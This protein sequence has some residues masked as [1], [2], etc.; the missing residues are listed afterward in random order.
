MAPSYREDGYLIVQPGS[1][2]TLVRFGLEDSLSPP[3]YSIPTKVYKPSPESPFYTIIPP[4]VDEPSKLEELTV[5]PIIKGEIVDVDALNFLLKSILKSILKDR[6]LILLN[7]IAL[8]LV[9]TSSRWSN[10]SI[11]SITQYVFETLQLNAFAIVPSALA[12]MFAYG[13]CSWI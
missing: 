9:Q 13:I 5:Y 4:T 3:S 6:P 10:A 1:Q 8:L 7:N 11:E 2:N 12:A